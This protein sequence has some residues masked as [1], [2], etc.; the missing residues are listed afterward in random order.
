MRGRGYES[1]VVWAL[2][3]QKKTAIWQPSMGFR[4]AGAG[5][6]TVQG[7]QHHSLVIPEAVLWSLAER[8]A[9]DP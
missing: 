5:S 4:S 8:E 7:A 1:A 6:G 9:F 2:K 3:V